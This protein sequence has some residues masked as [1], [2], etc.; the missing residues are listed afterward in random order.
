MAGG[1]I[2]K[3]GTAGVE[4]NVGRSDELILSISA[5]GL[6]HCSQQSHG[7]RSVYGAETEQPPCTIEAIKAAGTP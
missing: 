5:Q 1:C 2:T 4:V 3:L 7:A 6:I